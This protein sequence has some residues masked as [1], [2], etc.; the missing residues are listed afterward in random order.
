MYW[1]E[2][3]KE[4]YIG[5]SMVPM[6]AAAFGVMMM[7][8]ILLLKNQSPCSP[9]SRCDK[10]ARF[11][12]GDGRFC[13]PDEPPREYRNDFINDPE[14]KTLLDYANRSTHIAVNEDRLLF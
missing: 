5:W 9:N 12:L 10:L 8:I 2:T 13:C 4:C 11:V 1:C 3:A 7:V 6:P 14:K